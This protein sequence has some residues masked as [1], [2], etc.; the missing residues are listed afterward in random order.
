MK[1]INDYNQAG[2]YLEKILL[3]RTAPIAIKLIG[4]DDEIPVDAIRPN[5]DLGKHISLCQAMAMSRRQRVTILM[6]KD[7]EW[8]WA[9]LVAF[10]LVECVE[11]QKSFDVVVDHLGVADMEAAR[12]MFAS[13]PRLE[14]GKYKGILIAPLSTARFEPDLTLI[15]SNPA[16]LRSILFAVKNQSGQLVK[17]EFDAI[18]SC[19]YS[20]VKVIQEN[21]Y[22][23]T[24]P[25]PGEYE[26]SLAPEDEIIFSVPKDKT[27]ELIL[28]LKFFD[29]I[30]LGYTQFQMEMKS[31]YARP[32]FYNTLFKMWDLEEGEV[33]KK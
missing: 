30:K 25:D 24:I 26:R 5:K 31:D 21:Q 22:R 18:D 8:C 7:D 15:Y 9:P 1:T 2:E 17:S 29:E 14:Y 3:L 33:W 27:E 10:G 13:F 11:G 20:I 28:G 23:I 16:Q 19:V 6:T 4:K 12:K 32:D